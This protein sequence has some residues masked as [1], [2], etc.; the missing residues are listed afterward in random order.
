MLI[1]LWLRS[2]LIFVASFLQN[3]KFSR[4]VKCAQ[5]HFSSKASLLAFSS[6]KSCFLGFP[7][8]WSC[9]TLKC[10]REFG[11]LMFLSSKL[12]CFHFQTLPLSPLG[13]FQMTSHCKPVISI[14]FM[15][16]SLFSL[17]VELC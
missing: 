11:L 12:L 5:N 7:D 13:G 15:I 6:I 17:G 1:P 2:S 10:S 16:R 4:N 9:I 14:F 8:K 3:P